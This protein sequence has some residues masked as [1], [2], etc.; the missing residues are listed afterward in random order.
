MFQQK[1]ALVWINVTQ[2]ERYPYTKVADMASYL[3]TQIKSN[4]H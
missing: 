1:K 2:Q 3:H 4:S